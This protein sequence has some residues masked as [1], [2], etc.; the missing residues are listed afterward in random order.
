M[1]NVFES[2]V[3]AL[4]LTIVLESI[5]IYLFGLRRK[6]DFLAILFINLLTN[7]L[8]NFFILVIQS[9]NLMTFNLYS[10]VIVE[11]VVVIV[12]WRLL[13]YSVSESPKKLFVISL[14]MN[15]FSFSFG[16]ILSFFFS[17]P[18]MRFF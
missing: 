4:I 10:I 16:V 9:L 12:E 5:V 17:P 3:I 8:M 15:L 2:L 1:V 11:L 6:T 7:P 13:I 14:V 18:F